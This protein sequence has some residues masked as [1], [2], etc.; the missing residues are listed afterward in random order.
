ME[1]TMKRT[2]LLSDIA[3]Q[4][5]DQYNND[6]KAG[7]EPIYPQWARELQKLVT[8]HNK[9]IETLHALDAMGGL[10]LTTHNMIRA[11]L[12]AAEA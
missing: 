6:L 11:A 12:A 4:A 1:N 10:G 3:R 8:S 5:L 2:E 7:G 9:L